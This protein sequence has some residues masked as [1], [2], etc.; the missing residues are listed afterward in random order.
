MPSVERLYQMWVVERDAAIA[1]LN[2]TRGTHARRFAADNVRRL[3]VDY[4]GRIA[5]KVVG[6]SQTE[7]NS[8]YMPEV[9]D[10]DKLPPMPGPTPGVR[11]EG[12]GCGA[13]ATVAFVILLAI[14]FV[15]LFI[16]IGVI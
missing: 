5:R 4:S 1:E 7:L 2:N 13:A 11:T 16:E 14:L 8:G 9:Y 15:W 6:P 10:A 12:G 3:D